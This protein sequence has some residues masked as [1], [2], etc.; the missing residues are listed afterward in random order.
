MMVIVFDHQTFTLQSYGGI[1]RYF[2]RL[3]QG[4]I[5]LGH[6]ADV[7]APVHRN[8]YLKDL[9]HESVH[10]FELERFPPKT[11]RLFM[12]VN[13]QLS[14][15]KLRNKEADI[16][17]ETYYSDRLIC[18]KAKGRVIT[19][20]DMIHEKYA[21]EFSVWDRTADLKRLAVARADHVICISHSTRKDLCEIFDVPHHKVSVVHLGFEKF[22][23]LA[24]I[25]PAL[26]TDA[27]KRPYLLYVGSRGGYKNFARMLKAVAARSSLQSAFD[28]VAFG[29]GA[30][31]SAELALISA[32]GFT[33]DEVRQVGGGDEVLGHL[34]AQ[35]AAFVYPSVYEGFG[36]PPLEAMAH[37]CP[38]VTSNS[39]SMPE[40]V[41]DAGEYFDPLDIDAQ[42]DA[43]CNVVF[44]GQRRNQ[45]I[46]L[47]RQRLPMFSWDRCALETQAVYQQVLQTKEFH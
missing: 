28:V 34:Y 40:V 16:L 32:L 19:V 26:T 37:N 44:D 1:S 33:P 35:A 20:Y 17:H 11:G 6:Q 7:M 21:Q 5:A 13:N 39:S 22:E 38:V 43:I 2:V 30:F 10:G 36:L 18:P 47:G 9:P 3:M 24:P 8:R 4:L 46:E 15:F 25:S 23:Q 12:L 14:K 31:N 42:S 29:G 45:L 41:G 27:A